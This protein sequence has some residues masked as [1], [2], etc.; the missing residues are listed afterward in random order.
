VT[1]NRTG[2]L[3]RIRFLPQLATVVF[4]AAVCGIVLVFQLPLQALPADA[5]T[6]VF[7]AA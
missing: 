2:R 5:A 6:D 1:I 4:L 7:S 3:S